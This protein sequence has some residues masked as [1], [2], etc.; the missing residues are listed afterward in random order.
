MNESKSTFPTN[1]L[2]RTLKSLTLFLR[3][4][5]YV[6]PATFPKATFT[7]F[8]YLLLLSAATES[9]GVNENE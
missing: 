5:F 4:G 3:H 9:T 2:T 8:L 6:G 7:S 1:Y